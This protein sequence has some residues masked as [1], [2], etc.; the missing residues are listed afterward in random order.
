MPLEKM[1]WDAL[2]GMLT[3]QYDIQW[4]DNYD[5]QKK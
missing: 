3:D 2:F 5:G 1:F 4:M